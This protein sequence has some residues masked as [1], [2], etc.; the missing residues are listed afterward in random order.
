MP[1]SWQRIYFVINMLFISKKTNLDLQKPDQFLE[2]TKNESKLKFYISL[3]I[4]YCL[5]TI[6]DI[7]Q[8]LKLQIR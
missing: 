8:I 7:N 6:T 1:A 5:Q 3:A 4:E 2:Y